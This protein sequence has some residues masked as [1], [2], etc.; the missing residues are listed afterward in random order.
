MY[1]INLVL[2]PKVYLKLKYYTEATDLEISGMGKGIIDEDDIRMIDAIIF[3]QECSEASTSLD[4]NAQSEIMTELAHRGESLK[5]W[6]IWWHSHAD[7]G[8]FF[9]GTD[10]NTIDEHAHNGYLISLVTNKAGHYE[11]RLDAW[12]KHDKFD[13]NTHEKIKLP[14]IVEDNPDPELKELCEK[15]VEE[16]ITEEKIFFK[17][18]LKSHG[19]TLFNHQKKTGE[20][21][22]PGKS[23]RSKG[24]EKEE[25]EEDLDNIV[26]EY[27]YEFIQEYENIR[28]T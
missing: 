6:N 21:I 15:E 22:I 27:D 8:V 4:N 28:K 17:K 24:G 2:T 14:V 11:A 1:M 5:D 26:T 13:I 16:K 18:P 19:D 3:K 7:L 10:T 9:S 23:L 12:M 20:I 25:W